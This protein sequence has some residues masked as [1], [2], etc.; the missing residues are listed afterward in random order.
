MKYKYILLLAAV[1]F[2][3]TSCK[4]HL[5]Q[6]TQTESTSNFKVD[7]NAPAAEELIV[8]SQG[9][10]KIKL[11]EATSNLVTMFGKPDSGDAAMGKRVL[12]WKSKP[13][14]SKYLTQVYAEKQMGTDN[15]T[16]RVK[17][18]RVTSPSFVTEKGIKVG[19]DRRK[20][21]SAYQVQ[22]VATFTKGSE[23]FALFDDKDNG[24]AF[25]LDSKEICTAVI[26]HQ[27]G[28][29]ATANYR[30]FIPQANLLVK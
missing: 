9:I 4:Q 14:T 6:D 22:K 20:I 10:G 16:S 18:I 15:D 26:V 3:C 24:I 11:D 7:K 8:P 29:K 19:T 13:D 2:T 1:G 25:E 27:H 5:K 23:N 21:E 17:L 30:A 28:T 12:S